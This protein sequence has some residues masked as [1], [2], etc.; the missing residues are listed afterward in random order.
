MDPTERIYIY[1][2]LYSKSELERRIVHGLLG[3]MLRKFEQSTINYLAEELSENEE[4][5]KRIKQKLA[6]MKRYG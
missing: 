3:D 5:I 2:P 6:E 4:E 1:S